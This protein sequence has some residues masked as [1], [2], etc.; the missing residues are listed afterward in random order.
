VD[1]RRRRRRGKRSK[2]CCLLLAVAGM[3]ACL[4]RGGRDVLQ[5][6]MMD[7]CARGRGEMSEASPGYGKG[8]ERGQ[9]EI[10]EL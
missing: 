5:Q 8:E 4:R 2:G 1:G 3:V 9:Y 10:K 6:L 7:A